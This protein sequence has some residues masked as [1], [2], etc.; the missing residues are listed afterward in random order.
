MKIFFRSS[1]K[2]YML[3]QTGPIAIH[4][5]LFCPHHH[6]QKDASVYKYVDDNLK[7]SCRTIQLSFRLYMRFG[8]I[9]TVLNWRP[10]LF[11]WD[12][13]L[14][15]STV[16]DIMVRTNLNDNIMDS[17]NFHSFWSFTMYILQCWRVQLRLPGAPFQGERLY[18]QCSCRIAVCHVP[19]P[20]KVIESL[21]YRLASHFDM[22]LYC[23]SFFLRRS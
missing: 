17:C 2:T 15:I 4:L 7:R 20:K 3:L 13:S 23:V 5:E 11:G 14:K 6:D 1:C 21:N 19:N 8:R 10:N 9:N 12:G 18:L 16:D 22:N